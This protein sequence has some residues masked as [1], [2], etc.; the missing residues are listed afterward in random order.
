MNPVVTRSVGRARDRGVLP[1]GPVLFPNKMPNI[2][3]PSAILDFQSINILVPKTLLKICLPL[4]SGKS[5]Q[6]Q[7]LKCLA[8]NIPFTIIMQVFRVL[9]ND[10]ENT[11]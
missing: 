5:A 2:N 6:S 11:R 4:G 8:Q 1:D 9:R 3:F 7:R 10:R